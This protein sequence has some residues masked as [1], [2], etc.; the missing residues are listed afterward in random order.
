MDCQRCHEPLEPGAAFCG[1]CGYPV[2]SSNQSQPSQGLWQGQSGTPP[3]QP[4]I[5][6]QPIPA[7]LN[8]A[9]LPSYAIAHPAQH[10]GETTAVLAVILGTIGIVGSGFL[11]PI[12]GLVFGIIGMCLG[13]VSRRRSHRRL[14]LIG[15]AI[16]SL[17]VAAG[18]AALVWNI[19]HY[20]T[21]A[22]YGKTGQSTTSSKVI[23]KLQ[24]PCYS[25]NLINTY[26]ISNQSGNCSVTMY[27]NQTFAT[28][29]NVYKIVASETGT[30]NPEAFTQL[31]R[32][33]VDTDIHTNLPGFSI[34]RQGPSS[35]AGSLAYTA[36]ANNNQ[37]GT[38]LME[39]L[40]LHLGTKDNAFDI[41]HAVNG[42][43]VNLQTLEARWRWQ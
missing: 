35:F 36:Y 2:Q 3:A 32:Q 23:S 1:N 39:T 19:S 25:F 14:A 5:T 4:P 18:L 42:S 21:T 10:V 37:Q 17:A 26:N 8:G 20:K 33:A 27:N 41:I 11:I 28:S 15:L 31:A 30:T 22:Q 24:T 43:S 29:T 9:A 7:A 13:T 38:A 6:S 34:T 16:A 40:V 12:I